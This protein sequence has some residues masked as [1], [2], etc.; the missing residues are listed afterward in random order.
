[1]PDERAPQPLDLHARLGEGERRSE[2]RD[3]FELVERSPC[4]PQAS[5]RHHWDRD[6]QRR[7][8]RREDQRD[9]VADAARGMLVDARDRQVR[10]IQP[11]SAPEHRVGQCGDL[12]AIHATPVD[13][14]EERRHLV[15]GDV[16]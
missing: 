1:L 14:H 7:D 9:L 3:R 16:A 12:P 4:M 11:G 15:V 10:K 2:S 6:T 5:T 13:G 8:E